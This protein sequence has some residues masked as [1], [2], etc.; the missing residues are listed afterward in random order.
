MATISYK[1]NKR[2]GDIDLEI[3]VK[4]HGHT[5]EIIYGG[6]RFSEKLIDQW[7]KLTAA[8]KDSNGN[9]GI[10]F[11]YEQNDERGIDLHDGIVEFIT[12]KYEGCLTYFSVNMPAQEC[13]NMFESASVELKKIEFEQ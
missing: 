3:T 1:I 5:T 9:F 4:N 2:C 8:A 6:I 10:Y 11:G 12:C 7:E 13:I